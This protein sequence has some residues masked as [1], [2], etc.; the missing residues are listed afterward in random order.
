MKTIATV[1]LGLLLCA[2]LATTAMAHGW[3]G[4]RGDHGNY[5]NRGWH[6]GWN[7]RAEGYGW[8]HRGGGPCR[9]VRYEG[10]RRSER[11]YNDD[12]RYQDRTDT[13]GGYR[14]DGYREDGRIR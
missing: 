6:N 14:D 10:G 13:R 8:S 7:T 11:G 2:G 9:D 3:Q 4:G 5:G 1:T 12:A